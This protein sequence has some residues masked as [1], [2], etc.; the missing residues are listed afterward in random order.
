MDDHVSLRPVAGW[1]DS[2][3]LYL[4]SPPH[5]QSFDRWISR[6][7]HPTPNSD[8]P[9]RHVKAH[10]ICSHLPSQNMHQCIIYDSNEP[11]ARLIGIEYVIPAERFQGL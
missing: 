11:G 3:D 7:G 6:A 8:E 9:N 5:V 4:V 2:I 10:H 1:S